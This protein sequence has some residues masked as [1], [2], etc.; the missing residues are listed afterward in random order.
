MMNNV[1]VIHARGGSVRV[2]RKNIR[3]LGDLPLIAWTIQAAL[4]SSCDRVL[5]STD[6]KE[7]ADI[8][9]KFGAEVPF[10]RPKNI[11]E[12]VPSELVTQHAINFHES[13]LKKSIKLAITIQPTTPFI[14]N[15]DID[16]S[17][18]LINKNKKLDSVFTAGPI[19]QRPEWM[20]K[21]NEKTGTAFK[22]GSQPIKGELG[23]SQNLPELWHPNGGVYVTTRETLFK[24]NTLIGDNPA[25]HKMNL[26]NS[27]DIDEEIDFLIAEKILEYKSKQS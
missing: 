16:K 23:I 17:I 15:L 10:I 19:I 6:D 18:E 26:I 5:V 21:I 25:I 27:L 2:P 4:K 13:E 8:S 12:D 9:I 20:F 1:A 22:I 11:S 14:T 24:R 3:K 7:I